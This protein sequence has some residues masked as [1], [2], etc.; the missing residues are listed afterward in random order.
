MWWLLMILPLVF[1]DPDPGAVDESSQPSCVNIHSAYMNSCSSC[2]PS[3]DHVTLCGPGTVWSEVT[4]QCICE[5]AQDIDME[6]GLYQYGEVLDNWRMAT[7]ADINAHKDDFI[8][9]YGSTGIP[10]IQSFVSDNCCIAVD[11]GEKLI[12]SGT[13]YGY[14]FPAS[15]EGGIRCNPA[16]GYSGSVFFYRAA[17]LTSDMNFTSQVACAG[18][19]NP[20]IYIRDASSAEANN[21]QFGLGDH[22]GTYN[23]WTLVDIQFLNTYKASFVQYY[24]THGLVPIDVFQS[25]NCCIALASGNKL[26]ISG[27]PY[28]YQFPASQAGGIRCN[29]SGGYDEARYTF[30]RTPT[31]DANVLFS[32]RAACSTSHNPAIWYRFT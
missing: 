29:P 3:T 25:G 14:Q 13:P 9:Q 15:A 27:T 18:S 6:F 30:Y 1:A 26:I 31:L 20:T 22:E 8:Q 32:E 11:G 2:T 19:A 12:I 21:L 23:G 7:I 28:G 17:T 4:Q 10:V 5:C 24:N 16:G